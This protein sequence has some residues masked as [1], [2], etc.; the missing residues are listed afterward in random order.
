L[1]DIRAIDLPER[2]VLRRIGAAS[3]IA[4]CQVIL[5]ERA[6]SAKKKAAKKK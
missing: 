5:R 1:A 6:A 2:R 3:I 4:P